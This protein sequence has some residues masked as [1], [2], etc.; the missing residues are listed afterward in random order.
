LEV[1]DQ[2][3]QEQAAQGDMHNMAQGASSTHPSLL[4]GKVG[5]R[6][7]ADDRQDTRDV[8]TVTV[9]VT[10]HTEALPAQAEA[11]LPSLG[12]SANQVFTPHFYQRLPHPLSNL[13]K[14]ISVV[15]G[16][17]VSLLC[18]FLLKVLKI[19]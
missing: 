2:Q 6:L 15:D 18:D 11:G 1:A 7:G 14:E 10:K 16:T 19:C 9:A 5:D 3:G 8:S 17:D 12:Q 4:S 13:L